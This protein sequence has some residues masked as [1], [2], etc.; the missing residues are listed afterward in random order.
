MVEVLKEFAAQNKE[1]ERGVG[2]TKN[3][4]EAANALAKEHG[5][6]LV[7]GEGKL[8]S[9]KLSEGVSGEDQMGQELVGESV[10]EVVDKVEVQGGSEGTEKEPAEE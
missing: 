1:V 8:S 2:G 5:G 10:F 6:G 7:G 4:E 9:V 3:I